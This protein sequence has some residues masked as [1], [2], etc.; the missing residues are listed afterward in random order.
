MSITRSEIDRSHIIKSKTR[1]TRSIVSYTE[2]KKARS[3]PS[4]RHVSPPSSEDDASEAEVESEVE[5]EAE[6]EVEEPKKLRR[7]TA[8]KKRK[9]ILSTRT[10]IKNKP[11]T[12][13]N[14]T[15]HR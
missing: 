10:V 7:P 3:K 8:I 12:S 9:I 11:T 4:T 1:R 13:A 6:P 15:I 14:R 2:E 5:S